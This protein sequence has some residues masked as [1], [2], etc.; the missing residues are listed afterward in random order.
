LTSGGTAVLEKFHMVENGKPVEMT[1]LYYLDDDQVK[2]THYCMAG[3]RPTMRG[4]YAPEAKTITF[5]LVKGSERFVFRRAEITPGDGSKKR[6]L[7]C[8]TPKGRPAN[9]LPF[10]FVTHV[11]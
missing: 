6:Q 7:G 2:L 11:Q 10:V 9:S 5:D 1:T 8:R 3:N 4:T